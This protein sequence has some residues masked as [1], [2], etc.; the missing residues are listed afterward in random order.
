[1]KI[2]I[3]SDHGGFEQKAP[4]IERLQAAGF[5]VV[6]YGPAT[7]DRCDYPDFAPASGCR[8]RRTN[9]PAYARPS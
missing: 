9:A 2:A 1:M 4:L 7:D 5:D 8:W 6:D 3:A